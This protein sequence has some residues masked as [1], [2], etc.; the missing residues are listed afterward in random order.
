MTFQKGHKQINSGRTWFKKGSSP[1]LGKKGF[2]H[3]PESKIKI[4][5]AS[6]GRIVSDETR[7]RMSLSKRGDKGSNWQGGLNTNKEYRNRRIE[8]RRTQKLELMAGR[9]KSE[10]CELCGEIN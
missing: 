9:K 1:N 6:R 2:K 10:R 8:E 7:E 4:G 5:L 3:S